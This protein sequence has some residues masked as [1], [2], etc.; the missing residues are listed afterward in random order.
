MLFRS[1]DKIYEMSLGGPLL[2]D[3]VKFYLTGKLNAFAHYN[4]FS[5]PSFSNG[6]LGVIDPA[7]WERTVS[8]ASGTKNLDGKTPAV[9]CM[10]CHNGSTHPKAM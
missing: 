7:A 8:I 6:G 9:T 10:T 5:D 4:S 2:T 1:G 3:E